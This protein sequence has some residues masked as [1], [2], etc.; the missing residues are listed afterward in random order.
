M[1]LQKDLTY[2]G[3][4]EIILTPDRLEITD[5]GIGMTLEVL[6]ENFWKAGSSGKRGDL[7][8]QA[9]VVGTFG[10]GAMANFGV[11]KRLEVETKNIGSNETYISIADRDS[12]SIS[13]ECIELKQIQDNRLPGTKIIAFL[14]EKTRLNVH[15]SI[16]YIK[17]YIE[18]LPIK[19]IINGVLHSQKNLYELLQVQSDTINFQKEENVAYGQFSFQL[20]CIAQNNSLVKIKVDNLVYAGNHVKGELVLEQGRGHIM[21]YRNFFGLAPIPVSQSYNFGGFINLSIL[22]PTAGRE[23]IGRD[24]I[25]IINQLL[26]A[27]ERKVSEGIAPSEIADRNTSFHSYIVNNSR[28]D[29]AGNIKINIKPSDESVA[30]NQ[31]KQYCGDKQ[32]FYYAGHDASILQIFGNENSYLLHLSQSNPRRQIQSYYLNN[33]L[34]INQVPDQPQIKR[35]LSRSEL[36]S[37]E[38]AI[39][40]KIATVISDD[41]LINDIDIEYAEISHQIP[42]LVKGSTNKLDIYLSNNTDAINQ[43][44]RTYDTAYEVFNGFVKDFVRINLYPKFSQFVPSSTKQ[45]A[46]ALH[47]I[48]L[49]NRELY[50]YEHSELGELD[51]LLSDYI[52]GKIKFSDVLNKSASALKSQSQKVSYNQVGTIENEIPNLT[53]NLVATVKP[54]ENAEIAMPAIMRSDTESKM[55]LLITSQAHPSLNNFRMFLGASDKLFKSEKEFFLEP[56]TT[57]IIYGSHKVVYIFTHASQKFSLYY[58]IELKESLDDEL[59]GGK[60]YPTTTII[61]KNRIFF[62]VPQLI[63][64]AFRIEDGSKEFYIRYDL[65]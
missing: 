2:E 59:I 54:E 40:F 20:K 22:Q 64:N 47:K 35:T 30:L 15:E 39:L 33:V 14:D 36:S 19:V 44:K 42:Y 50:K 32:I 7:A 5:N 11:C 17:P 6:Q 28:Y 60:I 56:H 23:A 37:S 46:D 4:I 12:L 10:I 13:E 49:R 61:T 45:G 18:Y 65:I 16:N 3:L 52:S 29:L 25:N 48:L 62:P 38:A 9:G 1:H 8:K 63:E 34:R 55:K 53:D 57:K 43:L 26:S 24:S 27:V 58:D 31:I 41:Y 51:S 21:G